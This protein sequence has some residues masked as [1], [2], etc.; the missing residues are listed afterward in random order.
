MGFLIKPQEKG[1]YDSYAEQ[2]LDHLHGN[3]VLTEQLSLDAVR[4]LS[5]C[6]DNFKKASNQGFF[7]RC[8]NTMTGVNGALER[9]N[10]ACLAEMQKIGFS[11]LRMIQEN[12]MLQAHSIL[13]LK[14]NLNALAIKEAETQQ[15]ITDLAVAANDRFV[16]LE[17]RMDEC[18]TN[19]NLQGW[20]LTLEE[21]ELDV[22][23]PTPHIRMLEVLNQFYQNKSNNWNNKDLLFMR[24]ALRIVGINPKQNYS[25]KNF[26][27]GLVTEILSGNNFKIYEE[28][29][30]RN[31]LGIDDNFI[32]DEIS[33]P[34]FVTMHSIKNQY[35]DRMDSIE[36]F[37]EELQCSTE[38]ALSRILLRKLR[39]INV[40]VNYESP[41]A[42]SCIEILG[43]LRLAKL[44]GDKSNVSES[45]KNEVNGTRGTSLQNNS[46]VQNDQ[47][48][49]SGGFDISVVV[50]GLQAISTTL[51]SYIS[52]IAQCRNSISSMQNNFNSEVE[53]ICSQAESSCALKIG[54]FG[55]MFEE[56]EEEKERRMIRLLEPKL[57]QLAESKIREVKNFVY[58]NDY[59]I[60]EILTQFLPKVQT[61]II[62]ITGEP[63]EIPEFSVDDEDL[64]LTTAGKSMDDI[65]EEFEQKFTNVINYYDNIYNA[66]T[67]LS[68][69]VN[70]I[71]NMMQK[72]DSAL[73]S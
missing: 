41:L 33:S 48:D 39:Q 26:I 14:N 61:A 65:A 49:S 63:F 57:K 68:D 5:C 19:V 7:K 1:T 58:E 55:S 60:Q 56:T 52:E 44:L 13:S 3:A 29:L 69:I 16:E 46:N 4:L 23:Y 18:E 35:E 24:K 38:E 17:R 9:E 37:K 40:N 66:L 54:L 45:A 43:C 2:M 36:E 11:F 20:L 64:L 25:I 30:N 6:E 15:L 27:S 32:V 73:D 31:C 28:E 71:M 62:K 51:S 59:K 34:I 42:E 53:K 12:Q 72:I 70:D 10:V 47:A 22:L 50:K 8:W 21:R 67:E